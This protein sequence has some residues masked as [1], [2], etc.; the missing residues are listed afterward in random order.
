MCVYHNAAY[1]SEKSAK[2][3]NI[4][5]V[6]SSKRSSVMPAEHMLN[7][8]SISVAEEIIHLHNH[9]NCLHV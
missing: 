6:E 3:D 4:C 7:F 1:V 9:V 8:E 2:A 5:V